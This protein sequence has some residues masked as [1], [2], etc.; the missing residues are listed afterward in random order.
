M[1]IFGSVFQ[2][3]ELP[4]VPKTC[5]NAA[6]GHKT[7]SWMNP[8]DFNTT[9]NANPE[10]QRLLHS[11]AQNA[12]IFVVGCGHSG[13]TEL[14]NILGRHPMIFA[15]LDGPGMEYAVQPNSFTSIFSWLPIRPRGM[16]SWFERQA[17]KQKPLA[18]HWAIK[19]PSNICRLG[20]ILKSLPTARVVMLVRDGRDSMISL[21]A[22]FPDAELTGP[23]VL[24][25]WVNDNTAGLLFGKDPRVMIVRLEDLSSDPHRLLPSIL[26]HVGASRYDPFTRQPHDNDDDHR[27]EYVDLEFIDKLIAPPD[28]ST[29][30]QAIESSSVISERVKDGFEHNELRKIQVSRPLRPVKSRWKEAMT[31]RDRFV[32]KKSL[33]AMKLLSHFGYANKTD[34]W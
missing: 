26:T 21:K 30:E 23:L 5:G 33:Q 15:Y 2:P 6:P 17:R 9:T 29:E 34:D 25:R 28:W 13:T 27:L 8:I 12:P 31:V 7:L 1:R 19:S 20:Y 32:F 11:P 16:A 14:I 3:R 4:G 22:R 24:G 10:N 18:T